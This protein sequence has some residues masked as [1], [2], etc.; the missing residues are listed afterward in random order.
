[1]LK[2]KE[3]QKRVVKCTQVKILIVLI[4]LIWKFVRVANMDVGLWYI[5][6]DGSLIVMDKLEEQ[7]I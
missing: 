7:I 5:I 3:Y 6:I 1:M 4:V 2:R